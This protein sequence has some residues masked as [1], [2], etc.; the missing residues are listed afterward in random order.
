[1]QGLGIDGGVLLS[2]VISFL[3]LFGLLYLVAYKPLMR[4]LD[5][6]SRRIK[7]SMDQTDQIKEQAEL[8]DKETAKRIEEA[9]KEG[10]KLVERAMQAGEEMKLRAKEEARK[11]AEM[12][13]S[14]ART[15][16]ERERDDAIGELRKEF[17]DL[18]IIAA[19][20][21][22]DRSLDKKVHRELIDKV[23]EESTI[24]KEE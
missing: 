12:L 23:L 10:Q 4:M 7:E 1:M 13:V 2:Q 15:E 24:A 5:E 21:V 18:T 17:A 3:V 16:I 20:K 19:E 22:I 14:R 8:A 9:N 6:R 11:E